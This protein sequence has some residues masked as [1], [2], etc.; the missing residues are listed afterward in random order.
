MS[1]T[2]AEEDAL[3]SLCC[4]HRR[5]HLSPERGVIRMVQRC[6]GKLVSLRYAVDRLEVSGIFLKAQNTAAFVHYSTLLLLQTM[7]LM[8]EAPGTL[9][10]S[11]TRDIR[12]SK[13]RNLAALD[14]PHTG[15][16][17]RAA[18]HSHLSVVSNAPL[19]V[20]KRALAALNCFARGQRNYTPSRHTPIS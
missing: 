16:A 9:H 1:A 11:L 14:L 4:F 13:S 7:R 10:A 17:M 19:P 8:R 20:C 6:P 18:A 15:I 5:Q 3:C 12:R 2:E